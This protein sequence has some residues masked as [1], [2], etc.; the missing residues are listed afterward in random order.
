METGDV[1]HP[2]ELRT[3]IDQRQSLGS[4]AQ[5]AQPIPSANNIPS[6]IAVPAPDSTFFTLCFQKSVVEAC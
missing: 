4:F 2:L 6:L 1:V 3:L 5:I